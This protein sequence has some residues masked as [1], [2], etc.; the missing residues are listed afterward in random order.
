[1]SPLSQYKRYNNKI[2]MFYDGAYSRRIVRYSHA[3]VYG[4]AKIHK[5]WE[6]IEGSGSVEKKNHSLTL[7]FFFCEPPILWYLLTEFYFYV[8]EKFYASWLIA[9]HRG[10]QWKNGMVHSMAKRLI[11]ITVTGTEEDD[12]D[13]N[14]ALVYV[15]ELKKEKM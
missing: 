2:E 10:L 14:E 12:D 9:N 6:K 3:N 8:I 15:K 4:S 7:H 13:D 1:M 11:T 5:R